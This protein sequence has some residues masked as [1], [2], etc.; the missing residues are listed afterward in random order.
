MD[1]N[2]R[3]GTRRGLERSAGHRAGAETVEQIV[4]AAADLGVSVLTLFA[5]SSDN[6]RRPRPEVSALMQLLRRY[7][8]RE[9]SRFVENGVRLSVVGRR[10][11][12]H[13][14]IVRAIEHAERVT[15]GGTRL[16]LRIAL[17]YSARDAIARAAR[18]WA[19]SPAPSL[20]SLGALITQADGDGPPIPDVDLLIRTGGEQ[21]LSDFL[22]WECAYAELY[23]TDR[24]WPDF[25][26]DD[27]AAALAEFRRRERRFGD[28][29]AAPAPASRVTP[30]ARALPVPVRTPTTSRGWIEHF[31]AN[32]AAR[33]AI[34]SEAGAELGPA[35]LLAVA[36]SVRVFQLGEKG[37]GR[38]LVRYARRYAERTGDADYVEA[39]RMLVAEEQRH[40]EDLGR[41]MTAHAIPPLR[42][43]PTHTVFCRLR[44]VVRTLEIAVA[45]LVTAEIVAKAYYPLLHDATR[46]TVLRAI[47]TQT[48]RDERRHVEFQTQ[49]LGRLRA[50]RSLF[51]RCATR[52]LHTVLFLGTILVVGLGHR[53]VF[54]ASGQGMRGFWRAA[55]R[56]FRRDLAVM[57]PSPVRVA[58]GIGTAPLDPTP[59]GGRA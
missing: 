23:F 34:P 27:L 43:T 58:A 21:R 46:S 35:E 1:G 47:C 29:V 37:E 24:L 55:W 38:D 44:N 5:F 52:A 39:V 9:T 13:R 4:E 18:R 40:A 30:I 36:E 50:G 42:H 8:R 41:F 16:H 25:T 31:R 57:Q 51:G 22:L 12:L 11:R 53:K 32:A 15:R 3:W 59:L 49:M 20:E 2:G 10:D 6:W 33:A 56:E 28:V 17:D 54:H 7:V 45:V 14:H 19:A 48:V 26:P